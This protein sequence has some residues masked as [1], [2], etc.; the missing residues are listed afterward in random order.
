[1]LFAPRSAGHHGRIMIVS[2]RPEVV[3]ELEPVLRAAEHVVLSVPNGEEALR[4][5]GDGVVPDLMISDLGSDRSLESLDYLWRFRDLNRVGRHL[6]VVEEGAPF[7]GGVP[8]GLGAFDNLIPLKRPFRAAQVRESVADAIVRMD[9]DIRALRGEMWREIDRMKEA[10][11]SVHRDIVNALAATIAARDPYMH[12]HSTRV[13]ALCRRVATTLKLEE[14]E[15]D[16]LETA[17]LLHEI[18][19]VSVPVEL[20]HKTGTLTAEE[21]ECIRGHARVGA[22][23]VGQV[24]ALREAAPLIEHQ[25]TDYDELGSHQNADSSEF[26][27][28]GVLRV[29][30]AYD[31]M[32]HARSYRGA[33]TR[34]YWESALLRGAGSRFHPG[35]V[36]ALLAAL[37]NPV[38]GEG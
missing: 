29:V 12:G 3:A 34:D 30:D 36:N 20:L 2:D 24:P 27:L 26:L 10:M 7:S 15:I 6:V 13:A 22:E 9:G 14:E 23:I 32:T 8:G 5:L 19:K 37:E 1:M 33:L 25:G 28:T 35:V 17:A 16:L 38:E 11:R 21:L 18:G 31:A 4:I